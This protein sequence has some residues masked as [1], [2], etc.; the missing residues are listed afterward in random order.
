MKNKVQ[1]TFTS[2]IHIS[3]EKETLDF[4]SNIVERGSKATS[5]DSQVI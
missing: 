2:N 4:T 1:N 3:N 5:D